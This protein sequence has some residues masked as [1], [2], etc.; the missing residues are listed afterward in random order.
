MT[1]MGPRFAAVGVATLGAALAASA[2][3]AQDYEIWALD[4]GTHVLHIFDTELEEIAT[5]D[6]GEAGVR[7]PHMIDFTS[8]GAYAFIASTGSHDI[9]VIDAETREI[10]ESFDTGPRTHAATVLPDDSA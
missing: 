8:D 6:L 2:A 1:N 10:V 3:A 9:T 5:L 4:Q 7:V